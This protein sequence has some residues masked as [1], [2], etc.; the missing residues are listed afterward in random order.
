MRFALQPLPPTPYPADNP[1]S[2]AAVELG[3][4]LFFDPVLSGERDVS[5]ATCHHPAFGFADGRARSVGPGGTGLGPERT[6][7]VSAVSGLP[8]E[9]M[10]R[11]APTVFNAAMN[12]RGTGLPDAEGFQFWDGRALGLEAQA[13]L[14]IAARDEMR[15]DAYPEE[16]AHDSVVARLQAI[17]EY[18][19]R[20]E[21]AFAGQEGEA[22]EALAAA[23]EPGAAITAGRIARA[24]ATYER[25]LVTRGSSF[26]RYVGGED[27]ALS[28]LELEGLEVFFDRAACTQCHLGPGFSGFGF[29]VTGV[30]PEG[31]GGSVI[32]GD[33]TGREEHTGHPEDRYAFR[34]PGLRNVELTAPYMRNGVFSTLEEVVRFYDAGGRPRHPEIDDSTIAVQLRRPL[35]LSEHEIDALVSFLKT[36]TDPGLLLAPE[37]VRPPEQVPSGLP[38]VA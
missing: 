5:C 11:N 25:E 7:G 12:G 35:G 24:I 34:V 1:R 37:L 38:P 3:R 26:D 8:I 10:A 28:P 17:P 16:V 29:E 13:L 4:L 9:E 18:V 32:P 20:F 15:G 22:G 27:A 14:P 33:D 31:P 2:V 19:T 21:A 23:G 36:L 6:T 30:P